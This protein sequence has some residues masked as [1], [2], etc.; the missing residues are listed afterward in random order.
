MHIN[1]HHVLGL[2]VVVDQ[3]AVVQNLKFFEGMQPD[4]DYCVKFELALV[5]KE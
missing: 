3:P 1:D 5:L 4:R 2:H